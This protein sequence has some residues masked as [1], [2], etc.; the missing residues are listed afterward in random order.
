MHVGRGTNIE[1]GASFNACAATQ[2]TGYS[3]NNQHFRLILVNKSP[4]LHFSYVNVHLDV[5]FKKRAG[6]CFQ[7]QI[8]SAKPRV[9]TPDKTRLRVFNGFKISDID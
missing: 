4:F 1:T 6:V 7:V 9:F 2:N 5:L 3:N 8:I